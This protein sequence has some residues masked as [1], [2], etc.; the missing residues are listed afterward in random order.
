MRLSTKYGWLVAGS[1]ALLFVLVVSTG[2]EMLACGGDLDIFDASERGCSKRV[3]Q[4]IEQD[5]TLANK[6]RKKLG[7]RPLHLARTVKV[8]KILLDNG[9]NIHGT[10]NIGDTP[11]HDASNAA[12]AE[13]LIQSGASVSV[14]NEVRDSPLHRAR[15]AGVAEM[16]IAH[17]ADVNGSGRTS[18]LHAAVQ[19]SRADVI[20]ALIEKGANVDQTLDQGWSLLHAAAVAKGPKVIQVLYDNGLDVNRRDHYGATPLHV[21]SLNDHMTG[22]EKLLELG[23]DTSARLNSDVVQY[24][25]NIFT[26]QKTT[27]G[28]VSGKTPLGIARTPRMKALLEKN[29]S[30]K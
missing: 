18:P 10:D 2:C 13:F 22:A 5:A 12:V 15:N 25:T 9:A 14:F 17:G 26:Q 23:A 16:L 1:F 27:T 4:L 7:E 19:Y 11:L 21:A 28:D 30:S 29:S 24:Q 20:K 6:A 3:K 8:A